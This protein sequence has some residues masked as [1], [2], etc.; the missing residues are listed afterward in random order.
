MVADRPLRDLL[1]FV[2]E[3]L[4]DRSQA[5]YCLEHVQLR[6]RPVGYGVIRSDWRATITA[7][8]QPLVRIRPCPTGRIPFCSLP[9]NK[10]P[11]YD[12]LVPPGQSPTPRSGTGR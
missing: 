6:I 5:I 10:L 3:G 12:H 4:D 11:G 8:K 1:D 7:S 2:P 9:G